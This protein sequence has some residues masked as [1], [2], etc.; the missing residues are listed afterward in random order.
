MRKTVY[1]VV[2]NTPSAVLTWTATLA[3]YPSGVYELAVTA[4]GVMTDRTRFF[5]VPRNAFEMMLRG[6]P[7]AAGEWSWSKTN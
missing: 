5:E 6:Q 7:G 3:V 1:N 4:K 2:R